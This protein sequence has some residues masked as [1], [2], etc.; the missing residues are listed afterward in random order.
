MKRGWAWVL[1]FTVAAAQ[2]ASH[3]DDAGR[4]L[5][6]AAPVRRVVTLAPNLT[7]LVYA[8]GAGATLVGTVDTS[9]HP[10]QAQAVPRVGDYQRLDV[11]RILTL[12]PDLVLA[13]LSGNTSRELQQ[14]EAAGLRMFY[15]EPRKLADLPRALRRMGSLLGRAEQAEREAS[16]LEHE[17]AALRTSHAGAAPV[18][19]FFQVWSD[20]V[21]SLNDQHLVGEVIR[22]CGGRNV[23]GSLPQLVPQLS[24]ESVLAADPEVMISASDS[25]VPGAHWQRDPGHRAFDAWRRFPKL[26]AVRRGWLYSIPGDHISRQGPRIIEG[27][28][29]MCGALDEVRRERGT[30]SR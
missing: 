16:G 8:V 13:W 4:R 26:T 3:V 9:N 14:L 2:A 7:E 28:R 22:L 30:P 21:M 19:V 12:K 5:D 17:L 25:S 1:A 29:A 20:P 18:T 23:F 11:E 6:I 27:V 15:L 10:P 24:A